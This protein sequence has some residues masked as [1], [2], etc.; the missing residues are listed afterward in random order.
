MNTLV[1]QYV[2]VSNVWLRFLPMFVHFIQNVQGMF[3]FGLFWPLIFLGWKKNSLL[4]FDIFI[5]FKTSWDTE[6][7]C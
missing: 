6:T 4:N 5:F 2:L 7:P 1:V 3:L